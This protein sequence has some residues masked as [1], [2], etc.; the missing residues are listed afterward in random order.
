MT[1]SIF[2]EKSQR[3]ANQNLINEIADSVFG[4]SEQAAFSEEFVPEGCR[5]PNPKSQNFARFLLNVPKLLWAIR[6]ENRTV[7]FI[8]IQDMPHRNAMGIII[9][10]VY[11]KKGIALEA[12]NQIKSHPEI[13]YPI[14]GYTS[15]RNINAQRFMERLG[16]EREPEN[17]DFCGENSFKYKLG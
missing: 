1:N 14:F 7:G 12:F 15:I 6:Y 16:F 9:N 17:I 10:S 8:L 11:S 2:I 5:V 3:F 4:S 13:I